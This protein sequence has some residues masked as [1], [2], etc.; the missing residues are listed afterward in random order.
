MAEEIKTK[1]KNVPA[2]KAAPNRNRNDR[3]RG[4][5]FGR[6]RPQRQRPRREKPEYEQKILDIARV[7]RVTAGGRRFNFRVTMVIGNRNGKVGVAKGRGKDVA[8]AIDKAARS[9]QKVLFTVPMTKEGSLPYASKG[10]YSSARVMIQ[11]AKEGRGIIAGGPARAVC[12]LAGYK[13]LSSKIIGRSTNKLN[14]AMATVEALRAIRYEAP[15][16][17]KT[18][19]PKPKEG[20]KD[21]KDAPKKDETRDTKNKNA[22]TPNTK[23]KNA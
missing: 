14:N 2:G 9:A 15:E 18:E 4:G 3:Q 20:D 8:I 17:P 10:K 12:E 5:Q 13:N 23:T 21:K 7:T 22:D 11:P 19:E 1:Q 16:E 6:R